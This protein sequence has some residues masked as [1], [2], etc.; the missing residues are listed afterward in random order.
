MAAILIM[1]PE[2]FEQT[3][4][5]PF[6]KGVPIRNLSLIGPVV[7]RRRCLKMLTDGRRTDDGRL[8]Y[9]YTISSPVS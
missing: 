7:Q 3:F 8:S 6:F 4:V 9:K 5:P 1:C 2:L